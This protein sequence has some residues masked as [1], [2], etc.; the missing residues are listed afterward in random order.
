MTMLAVS[1]S[2]HSAT[3][4]QLS[5]LV[6][7]GSTTRAL[8]HDLVGHDSI[9]E[10]LVVST[11]NR[12]EVYVDVV[13][14]HAGLDAVIAEL[15]RHS[16]VPASELLAVSAVRY[17]DAAISHCFTMTA[18]LDSLVVG[19]N[20]ILGQVRA[21]LTDA[22]QHGT[23]GSVLNQV[24]QTALRVGKRV[25]SETAIGSAGRSI[26]TAALDALDAS[27]IDVS[28]RDCLVVGAGQ[29]AGLAAR[30]LVARGARITCAN[31]TL[32]NA[33]RL[34]NEVGGRAISF[35]EL[36]SA[37]A[38]SEVVVTCTGASGRLVSASS[39]GDSARTRA[40]IDLALP[41]DVDADVRDLG[42]VLVNLDGLGDRLAGEHVDAAA[43][44]ALVH[45]ELNR[46]LTRQRASAVTPTVVAL[47]QMADSVVEAEIERLD[48]RLPHLDPVTRE[49]V[50]M[51]IRR[52][53]D[54][55]M[56]QPTVAVRRAAVSDDPDAAQVDYAAVLRTLFA[57]EDA[58]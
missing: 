21:A 51:T 55:L 2:H 20:Q 27:G 34:A 42:V 54:K 15:A 36:D 8:G 29:M 9:R 50:V 28:G 16:S 52:V 37:V 3:I 39:L 14:F 26:F 12:T 38:S 48:R 23:T 4:E 5:R 32:V 22:Q 49:Q 40:I 10:A 24:F 46:F 45:D 13:R 35:T 25:H 33:Q 7:P 19:E 18:G 6:M 41:A 31:R 47:R 53:A 17:D 58:S 43:A 11:C 57:L 30:H 44:A 56:H 1:I